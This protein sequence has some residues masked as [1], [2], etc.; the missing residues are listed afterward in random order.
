MLKNGFK[1][2]AATSF[3][4]AM[5]MGTANAYYSGVTTS[6]TEIKVN[7]GDN[8]RT[9][10]RP[11]AGKWLMFSH[12]NAGWCE[13]SDRNLYSGWIKRSDLNRVKRCPAAVCGDQ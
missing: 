8:H 13:L 12:C 11:G 7:K 2:L 4:L 5:A 10:S 6:Q 9:V 1:I 3:A